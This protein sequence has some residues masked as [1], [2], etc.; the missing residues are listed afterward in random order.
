MVPNNK[1]KKN[2]NNNRA[3]RFFIKNIDTI[4]IWEKQL[5]IDAKSL[6]GNKE[7]LNRNYRRLY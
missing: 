3:E 2:D 4:K 1:M 7:Y 6:N 5:L